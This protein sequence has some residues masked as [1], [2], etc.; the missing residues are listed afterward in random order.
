[1]ACSRPRSRGSCA[2]SWP[3][4]WCT[5]SRAGVGARLL[6]AGFDEIRLLI[7]R[8]PRTAEKAQRI[9]DEHVVS[10]EGFS[11]VLDIAA[12]LMATPIWACWWD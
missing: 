7:S 11:R 1:M 5:P 12:S 4:T 8:P 2:P 10:D 3:R 9:A 6:E